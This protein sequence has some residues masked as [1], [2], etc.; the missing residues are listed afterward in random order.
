MFKKVIAFKNL[1][2]RA[3]IL[4]RWPIDVGHQKNFYMIVVNVAGDRHHKVVYFFCFLQSQS[5]QRYP[6]LLEYIAHIHT[7]HKKLFADTSVLTFREKT[8][9]LFL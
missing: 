4:N 5:A 3:M 9:I 8:T 1:C 7:I 2:H 6:S